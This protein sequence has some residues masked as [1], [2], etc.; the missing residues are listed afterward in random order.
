MPIIRGVVLAAL[1]LG[2]T[3]A[4]APAADKIKL[5]VA[6]A[7]HPEMYEELAAGFEKAHADIDI[8]LLPPAKDYD[9]LLQQVLRN[10]ITGS[11]PDVVFLSMNRTD[12]LADKKIAGPLDKFIAAET[13]WKDEGYSD[14]LAETCRIGETTYCLPFALSMPIIYF[15]PDLVRQA[16]GDPDRFPKSWEEIV[17]LAR[18]IQALPGGN[19]G[20]YFSYYSNT[21]NWTTTALIVSRGGRLMSPDGASIAFDSPEGMWM[22]ATMRSF[23]EAG[24]VEMSLDQARQSFAAGKLGI[25]SASSSHLRRLEE[26]VGEKF[27]LKSAAWPLA[28]PAGRL[29]AGGNGVSMVTKDPAKQQAAWAFIKYVTGPEGQPIM[30]KRSGYTPVNARV[31]EDPALLG[32]YFSKNPNLRIAAEEAAFI[33]RW[34]SFPGD[35]GQKASDV[36]RDHVQSVITLKRTPADVMPDMVR[37]VKALLPVPA[38]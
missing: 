17:D 2:F 26:Q 1:I 31:L 15:N 33:T 29:P 32:D 18:K 6:A 21:S 16:G 20:L 37:D 38:N 14:A 19:Q 11:L 12:L 28:Q 24:Q 22:L 27:V 5:E 9:Q 13:H 3:A 25:L 8:D 30:V 35:N 7:G 10:N 36:F 23:G 34:Q 4:G